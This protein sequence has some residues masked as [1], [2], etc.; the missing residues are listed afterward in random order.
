MDLERKSEQSGL[1][2]DTRRFFFNFQQTSCLNTCFSGAKND[3]D[4]HWKS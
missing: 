3:T 4:V 2:T 1:H